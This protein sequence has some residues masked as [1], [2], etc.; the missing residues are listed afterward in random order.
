[1]IGDDYIYD[2]ALRLIRHNQTFSG[3]QPP[4]RYRV[5]EVYTWVQGESDEPGNMQYTIPMTAQTPLQFSMTNIWFIDDQTVKTMFG[6]SIQTVGWTYASADGITQLRW[7][8]ASSDPPTDADRGVDIQ[9]GAT[10]KTGKI[11]KV[12]ASRRVVWVRNTGVTQFAVGDNPVGTGVD[13]DIEAT[14]G[15]ATGDTVYGNLFSVGTVQPYTEIYVAQEDDLMGGNAQGGGGSE[16]ELV[17]V[18]TYG[19]NPGVPWWDTETDFTSSENPVPAGHIDLLV[20]VQEAGSL[21]DAGRIAVYGR[22]YTRAYAH[23]E[24]LLTGGQG[25]APLAATG[26]DL[27]MEGHREV[28]YIAGTGSPSAG[29]VLRLTDT[30]GALRA[31]V[32]EVLSGPD[33]FQYFFIG[34]LTDF[35]DAQTAYIIGSGL[36]FTISNAT[37]AFA[38]IFG[39]TADGGGG[40]SPITLDFGYIAADV[41][42]DSTNENYGV[43]VACGSNPLLN[44][45]NRLQYVVKRGSGD[46]GVNWLP[47]MDGGNEDGQFYRA[48]GDIYA[49]LDAEAAAGLTE[50]QV[51]EGSLSGATGVVVAYNYGAA[52][53]RVVAITQIKG[54][55]VDNDVLD[56]PTP[57]GNSATI[58]GTPETIADLVANPF[59]QLAG[60]SFFGA[61]GVLLTGVPAADAN[62]FTLFDLGNTLREPPA[63]IAM[64]FN[65]VAV[66]D[67][68]LVAEVV[69]SG[70]ADIK[71]DQNGVGA[72]GASLG[73]TSIPVDSTPPNDTPADETIR[74]VEADASDE[75]RFRVASWTG[76]TVTLDTGAGLSGTTTSAGTPTQLIDSGAF[77]NFGTVGNVNIGDVIRKTASG[78]WARVLAK[79]SN[80]EITTTPLTGAESWDNGIAWTAN[81]VVV[82]L[83]DADDV[84]FPYMDRIAVG[85]S[86]NISLKYVSDR[87]VVARDRWAGASPILPFE[88]TGI[89]IESGGLTVAAN[90]LPDTISEAT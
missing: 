83:V 7:T 34:D 27:S 6:G 57:T 50:G 76:T 17:A 55:F 18:P 28:G 25:V 90:R 67:R 2:P 84:Y 71:T 85:T 4:N 81:T 40:Q 10:T 89:A 60:T 36:N 1:M 51:V 3:G 35:A 33:R 29:D 88:Q 23:F 58:F 86:E 9:V 42:D 68:L 49:V 53:F 20:K 38:D 24:L 31:I 26:N 48:V 14:F 15:V 74:C 69:T 12:D 13:F 32:T 56:A 78:A 21:I 73:A 30:N 79:V 47:D 75:Y 61:R 72:A 87:N 82:A 80:D 43:E 64:N 19:D 52:G 8:A 66:G 59:G 41:D 37:S 5:R 77:A 16:P 45:H 65:G 46:L 11:L 54:T 22:Q 44:V 39:A 62:N 70:T 63:T